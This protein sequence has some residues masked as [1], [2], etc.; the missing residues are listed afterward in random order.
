MFFRSVQKISWLDSQSKL[1]MLTLFSGCHIGGPRRSSNMVSGFK[2]SRRPPEF[3]RLLDCTGRKIAPNTGAN[4]TKLF[5]LA[6]KSWK[7][8]AKLATRISNHTL[9]RD[10]SDFWRFVKINMQQSSSLSPFLKR[11][12][13]TISNVHLSFSLDAILDLG[14][15][16]SC[17]WLTV[18]SSL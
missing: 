17:I 14:N 6:T 16:S 18:V 13:C 10:L 12:I 15:L 2:T 7:L 1:Q 4:A 3:R 11:N 9:P 8:V 5:T